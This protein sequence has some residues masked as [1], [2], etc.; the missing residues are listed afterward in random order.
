MIKE[1]IKQKIKYINNN[2]NIKRINYK[3]EEND[4]NE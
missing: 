2:N 3:R 1:I 4:Y